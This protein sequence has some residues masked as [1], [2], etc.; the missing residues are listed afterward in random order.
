MGK[1]VGHVL[2]D[3]TPAWRAKPCPALRCPRCAVQPG[4]GSRSG[5]LGAPL[6]GLGSFLWGGAPSVSCCAHGA[7]SSSA[8]RCWSR[9][10]WGLYAALRRLTTYRKWVLMTAAGPARAA[11]SSPEAPF[12]PGWLLMSLSP[13]WST[14]CSRSGYSDTRVCGVTSPQTAS[15]WVPAGVLH[16][17]VWV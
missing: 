10:I 12:Q 15:P 7:A 16:S 11:L 17:L 14:P 13:R 1:G 5:R 4:P 3:G 8:I 9:L 6:Q 2:W